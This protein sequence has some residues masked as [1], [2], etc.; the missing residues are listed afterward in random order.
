MELLLFRIVRRF[1]VDPFVIMATREIGAAQELS[2]FALFHNE[3]T[4]FAFGAR[5]L[6]IR[7]GISHCFFWLG[8]L[9]V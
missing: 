3:V 6:V 4:R 8:F 7:I 5:F 9:A 1:L 2:L